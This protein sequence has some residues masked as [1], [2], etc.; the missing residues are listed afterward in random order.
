MVEKI[1]LGTTRGMNE[2]VWI[3]KHKFDCGWYWAFGY[4]GNRNLHM[5]IE[6]LINHPEKHDPDGWTDVGRQFSR[7][8][9][10]QD[11]WWILRDL[12]ISA[13]ALKKAAAVYRRGGHQSGKAKPYRVD[14]E[15]MEKRINAD[16]E[17]LLDRLWGFLTTAR[18]EFENKGKKE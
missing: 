8:W 11:Q 1:F 5:H 15:E 16:L 18:A 13:Y 10:T 9:L 6:S 3:E 17:T 2:G 4:I 14:S 12:F 7:T